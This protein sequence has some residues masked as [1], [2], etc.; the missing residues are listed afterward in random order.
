MTSIEQQP[1][2]VRFRAAQEC[3]RLSDIPVSFS[4]KIIKLGRH[5]GLIVEFCK[6]D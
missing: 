6:N 3:V 2:G 5:L 1:F 4:A